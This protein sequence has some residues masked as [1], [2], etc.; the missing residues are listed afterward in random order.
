MMTQQFKR[1]ITP[2]KGHFSRVYDIVSTIANKLNMSE[3]DSRKLIICISEA[4]TNAYLHGNKGDPAKSIQIGFS[5]DD[6]CLRIDIDDQGTGD[7]GE[8][9]LEDASADV[10][11]EKTS[12]RGIG[13]MKKYA[14]KIIVGESD[15][16]GLRISI[17][18]NLHKIVDDNTVTTTVK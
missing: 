16:D 8:L 17:I 6:N 10:G 9:K 11:A 7:P 12:G 14:D 13:I 5:W 4:Y 3:E 15:I 2:V 18:W 1:T